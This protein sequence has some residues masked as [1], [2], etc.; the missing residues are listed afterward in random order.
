MYLYVSFYYE[1]IFTQIFLAKKILPGI[2]FSTHP[3]RVLSTF[4]LN[5]YFKNIF[6]ANI[7]DCSW[8]FFYSTEKISLVFCLMRWKWCLALTPWSKS[9]VKLTWGISMKTLSSSPAM[10]ST[11]FVGDH[12]S[13]LF[14]SSRPIWPMYQPQLKMDTELKYNTWNRKASRRQHENDSLDTVSTVLLVT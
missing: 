4:Y 3:Y 2:H 14:M 6:V 7:P 12:E 1:N 9:Q 8:F 5:S 13:S 11:D 10:E